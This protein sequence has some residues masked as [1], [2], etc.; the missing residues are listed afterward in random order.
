[1]KQT[2]R[3]RFESEGEAG[4]KRGGP[5]PGRRRAD[6]PQIQ[7]GRTHRRSEG[8]H[9]SP[10]AV[11]L[12]E[13]LHGPLQLSGRPARQRHAGRVPPAAR[14]VDEVQVAREIPCLS[15]D[16][17]RRARGRG[18]LRDAER[19]AERERLPGQL[20]LDV[21]PDLVVVCR[22]GPEGEPDHV[23]RRAVGCRLDDA[24]CATRVEHAVAAAH[25]VGRTDPRH[26]GRLQPRRAV[27]LEPAMERRVRRELTANDD[28]QPRSGQ[29]VSPRHTHVTEHRRRDAKTVRFHHW[30][31]EVVDE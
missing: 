16:R 4:V 2:A 24:Q 6:T 21:N 15:R 14:P 26:A 10:A 30:N 3:L 27:D 25:L 11:A 23:R 20:V 19:L 31:H 18:G 12:A 28:G 29:A 8:P 17:W 7:V 5:G 13:L 1:M 22:G 9:R